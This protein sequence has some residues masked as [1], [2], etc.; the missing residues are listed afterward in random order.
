MA[1]GFGDSC[2]AGSC[3]PS[4]CAVRSGERFWLARQRMDGCRQT[5]TR[6]LLSPLQQ[7]AEQ[8]NAP[9]VERRVGSGVEEPVCHGHF[10]L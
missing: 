6:R 9:D 7:G 2:R 5:L 8:L 10:I 3:E 1:L 4:S